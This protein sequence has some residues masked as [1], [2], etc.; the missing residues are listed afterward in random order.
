MILMKP[1]IL[2]SLRDN[3]LLDSKGTTVTT[4]Y[5]NVGVERAYDYAHLFVTAP[6][7][8]NFLEVEVPS[9]IE[10]A[11]AQPRPHISPS[12]IFGYI[13]FE[14]PLPKWIDDAMQ[15]ISMAYGEETTFDPNDLELTIAGPEDNALENDDGEVVLHLSKELS[16]AQAGDYIHLFLAAPVLL[17]IV[18]G[19]AKEELAEI[20]VAYDTDKGFVSVEGTEPRGVLSN[21]I[22]FICDL[23]AKAKGAI[24]MKRER[25][26]EDTM[27]H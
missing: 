8:L 22:R 15:A 10:A 27:P 16:K 21:R 12:L 24:P 5:K 23:V 11:N 14:D 26:S 25:N 13:P 3:M 9:A 6:E 18:E 1:E 2:L 17:Q 20:G 19:I 7:L 4:V